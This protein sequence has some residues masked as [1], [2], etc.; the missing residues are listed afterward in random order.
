MA[1]GVHALAVM[2][3]ATLAVGCSKTAVPESRS[4]AEPAAAPQQA[5]LIELR[6]AL[7]QA[8]RDGPSRTLNL[9]VECRR[10]N[11]LIAMQVLANGVGI[12]NDERQF[13]LDEAAVIKLLRALHAAD[14]AGM[15]DVYGGSPAA[16]QKSEDRA[17]VA[18]CRINLALDGQEKESVQLNKGEQSAVLKRLA[19]DLLTIGEGPAAAGV[20]ASSLSDGFEKIVRG[21]LAPEACTILLHRKPE[22]TAAPGANG[23]LMQVSGSTVTTQPYHPRNGYGEEIVRDLDAPAIRSLAREIAALDPAAWPVNL[24][25]RDYTDL[26]LRVLNH[27]KSIQARQFPNMHP[28]THGKRQADFDTLLTTLERLNAKVTEGKK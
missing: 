8:A 22:G 12:W 16:A 3:G 25:A 17:T 28:A 27:R 26:S 6:R 9:L 5:H 18:S 4:A 13:R 21:E 11:A 24:Y 15:K 7:E 20:T 2:L 14:F 10:E 1:V 23:F 19:E